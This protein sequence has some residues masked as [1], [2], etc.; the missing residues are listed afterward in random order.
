MSRPAGERVVVVG[1]GLAGITAALDLADAGVPVTLLEG[2]GWLGGA[3]FSFRRGELWVD[4]GQHVFLR[5]CDAYR[6]LLGRLGVERLVHLQPRL[7]IPVLRG[8][9]RVTW[10]RRAALPAPLHLAGTLAR[11]RPLAPAD[12]LRLLRAA[13]ALRR[14]DPADERLDRQTF[15]AW[16]AAHGQRPAAVAALWDLIALPTLNAPAA[17]GSL[18]LAAM[19]FRTGLLDRAD[20]AD[21]GWAG[22]PLARLHGESAARALAAAGVEVRLGCRARQVEPPAGGGDGGPLTVVAAGQ[23]LQASALVLAVP[24]D[25]A[26]ALLPPGALREPGRLRQLGASPI[27]NVHLLYDRP[28]TRLAFAAA[29]HSPVQWLFDRS[30]AA[31]LRDGQYL[32]VSLS[33]ADRELARPS[34]ELVAEHVRAVAELLPAARTARVRDA[35]VT[36]ERAATFRQQPGTRALRPDPCTGVP[37]LFLAGAWTDTGWPATMEGAVRSGVTAARQA[38]VTLGRTERLPCG[39]SVA[40]LLVAVHQVVVQQG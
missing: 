3:T 9:G 14:L 22:V 37:G 21:I 7:A 2:R 23:R 20:A 36:R 12:R 24:H 28:V 11:Y 16:L 30:A 38:L 18:A 19:V 10:L 4:N 27:V 29:L 39:R 13:T 15:G 34:G 1:G 25:Q 31:G 8:G 17:N 35:F 26:A 33:G 32:A 40:A 5:C 6:A